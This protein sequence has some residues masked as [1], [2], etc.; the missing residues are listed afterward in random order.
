MTRDQS[1]LVQEPD[2][3]SEAMCKE[4]RGVCY[5]TSSESHCY[6]QVQQETEQGARRET[7]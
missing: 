2:P 4:K 3:S 7:H 5:A 6:K 1:H